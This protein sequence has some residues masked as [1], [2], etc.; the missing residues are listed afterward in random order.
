MRLQDCD[1]DLLYSWLIVQHLVSTTSFFLLITDER[2]HLLP[3]TCSHSPET[4]ARGG[5]AD[6]PYILTYSTF[7]HSYYG[8]GVW[9]VHKSPLMDDICV[10]LER[11]NSLRP[12]LMRREHHELF[13]KGC[14]VSE[15]YIFFDKSHLEISSTFS[16]S[17]MNTI[18]WRISPLS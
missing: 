10:S 4:I 16:R 15:S 11:S 1:C 18:G 2:A 8:D 12:N 5:T 17:S 7:T 9:S 13:L 14:V 3:F 6:N